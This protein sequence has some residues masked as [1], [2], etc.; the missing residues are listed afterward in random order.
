M[1][2]Y[3]QNFRCYKEA[4]FEFPEKGTI[5]LEG[6]SGIGKSTI[7]KAINFVLYGKELKVIKHGEKKCKVILEYDNIK[8]TRTKCPNH[9]ILE[10]NDTKYEDDSAQCKIN[11]IWGEY[12]LYTSYMNQKGIDT[13]LTMNSSDKAA[14]L[15]KLSVKNFDVESL[16]KK[17]KDKIR[18]RKEL[19]IKN[20]SEK[21]VYYNMIKHKDLNEPIFKYEKYKNKK[22]QY[23]KK[24]KELLEK[25][26]EEINKL[27]NIKEKYEREYIEGI[28]FNSSIDS[29]LKDM[30]ILESKRNSIVEELEKIGSIEDVDTIKEKLEK[31][32]K[33]IHYINKVN[34]LNELKNEYE[35][36]YKDAVY[37]KET[38]LLELKEEIEKIDKEDINIEEIRKKIDII[39]RSLNI[40]ENINNL[41][42]DFEE[43]FSK[44]RC[45]EF[46]NEYV[47]GEEEEIEEITN[48]WKKYKDML[49]NMVNDVKLCEIDLNN[50]ENVLK[51]NIM[52]CPECKTHLVILNNNINK[53]DVNVDQLNEKKGKIK[54]DLL[55]KNKSIKEVK[56][57]ISKLDKNKESSMDT[58]YKLKN[59]IKDLQ[60]VDK[61]NFNKND[62]NVLEKKITEYIQNENRLKV[63]EKEYNKVLKTEIQIP[64]LKK[65][66]ELEKELNGYDVV[67]I[68][69]IKILESERIN[70]SVKL[71]ENKSKI[72]KEKKLKEEYNEVKKKIDKYSGKNLEKKDLLE[73]TNEVNN[74][75]ERMISVE[76]D[77][78]MLNRKIEYFNEWE[79]KDREYKEYKY[80]KEKYDKI[81]EDERLILKG[82][83]K[84]EELLKHVNDAETLSLNNVIESIN[85]SLEG[86]VDAFF[87]KSIGVQ[88][89]GYKE[90]KDN[91]KIGIEIV[92]NKEGEELTIDSL[93]GGEYDRV[94]LALFLSFNKVSKGNMILLDECLSSIHGELVED[95]VEYIKENFSEKLILFT[96][97]QANTGIFDDIVDICK[98]RI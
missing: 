15:Q 75:K 98:Y 20:R 86:I 57:K 46:I 64:T 80:I 8:V 63:L 18:E 79:I 49:D 60:N 66:Q 97:H 34:K 43:G 55:I 72:L 48:K 88:L 37:K 45:I 96:L 50:I 4:S 77:I 24:I 85:D 16:R 13:F 11:E 47:D 53:V 9:L 35:I 51:K 89:K 70:Y 95:I 7:F 22:E 2:L 71:E 61:V 73:I 69:D 56:E 41:V 27:K 82:L 52:K 39:K 29:M 12:F 31:I 87:D 93:S 1:R 17:I 3:L 84:S 68:R 83:Q 67:N 23:V 81:V 91:K 33:E 78:G 19:L 76:D 28:N 92:I 54:E 38:K 14:F 65:I 25:K 59:I 36:L 44:E 21:E 40:K 26:K 10:I 6:P 94:V 90:V 5:L 74:I 62:I 58:L 42:D 30:E 32:N